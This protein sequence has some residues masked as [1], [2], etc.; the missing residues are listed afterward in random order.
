MTACAGH[1]LFRTSSEGSRRS[2]LR[3]AHSALLSAVLCVWFSMCDARGAAFHVGSGSLIVSNST[4]IYNRVAND[5][6]G[7]HAGAGKIVNAPALFK[8]CA[9]RANTV[10]GYGTPSDLYGGAL[11]FAMGGGRTAVVENC[12]WEQ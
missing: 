2:A 3:T 5:F 6:E 7:Y 12:V 10:T 1:R 4:F 8:N 9:F 11:Y